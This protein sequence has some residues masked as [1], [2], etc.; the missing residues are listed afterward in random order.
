MHQ[1]INIRKKVAKGPSKGSPRKDEIGG[2]R[3]FPS[4]IDEKTMRQ[5]MNIDEKTMQKLTNFSISIEICVHEKKD[6][7][8]EKGECTEAT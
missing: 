2:F 6:N 8:F 5:S 4:N 3:D 7:T 1:Q